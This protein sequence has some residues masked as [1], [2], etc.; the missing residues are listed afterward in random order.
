MP[1]HVRDNLFLPPERGMAQAD[2]SRGRA[3]ARDRALVPGQHPWHHPWMKTRRATASA[4]KTFA[5]FQKGQVW[6]IGDLNLAVTAVGKTLVHHKRYTAQR[7]GIQTTLTS[8]SVL[9][10]YLVSG[11]A[12]LVAG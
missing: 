12:V 11:H 7:H 6:K 8:K 3:Q 5:S 10:K 4:L 2:P 9:R 1:Q